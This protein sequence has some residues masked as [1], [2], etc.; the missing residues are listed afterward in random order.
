MKTEDNNL[1]PCPK[2]AFLLQYYGLDEFEESGKVNTDLG[3]LTNLLYMY[4]EYLERIYTN[5]DEQIKQQDQLIGQ[6]TRENE[7]LKE[8]R[9]RRNEWLNKAKH[10]AG[11]S[12][13]ESFDGVWDDA[14]KALKDSR[15]KN[16]QSKPI[17]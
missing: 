17:A 13:G 4:D 9:R 1:Q 14:L 7:H 10:D 12:Y 11:Y 15:S 3:D 2:E 8:S 16:A 5:A 6:L